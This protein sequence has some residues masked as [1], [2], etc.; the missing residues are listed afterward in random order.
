M[1][2]PEA[3]KVS[4]SA[5]QQTCPYCGKKLESVYI[6]QLNQQYLTHTKKCTKNQRQDVKP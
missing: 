1:Q 2:I 6:A 3:K 4:V 5:W